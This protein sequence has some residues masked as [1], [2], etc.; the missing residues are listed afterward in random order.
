MEYSFINL[1]FISMLGVAA[2]SSL[3]GVFALTRRMALAGD[4]ISHIALPGLGLAILLKINPLIG[5]GVALIAGAFLIWMLEKRTR[6]ATETIIGIVFSASLALGSLLIESDEE[7]LDALFGNLGTL[8][9][10]ESV[11]GIALSLI[12]ILIILKLK[13]KLTLSFISED[14][15]KTVGLNVSKLNLI[16]LI[17]FVAAVLLGLQFLGVLLMGS[18]IIIP[19]AA[20]RNLARNF[21]SD[22]IVAV[23][24]SWISVIIGLLISKTYAISTGPAIISVAAFIFFITLLAKKKA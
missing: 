14:L 10:I 24:I 8:N 20:S 4:A 19:A 5:G 17:I 15:A 23:A 18:L 1:T 22:L 9:F 21:N 6:I 12:M 13:N 7:L 2:V 3:V 11:L 16:F